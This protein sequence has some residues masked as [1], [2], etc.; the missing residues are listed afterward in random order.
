MDA[1]FINHCN[2]SLFC[3]TNSAMAKKYYLLT[4]GCQMNKNDSQRIAGILDSL[5][6][7]ATQY[8]QEADLILLNTCSVRQ[9]AEDRVFGFVLNWQ[10][11]RVARPDLV[12]G[13]T[14]CMAGRDHDGKLRAKFTGVDLWFGIGN[15][16]MLPVWLRERGLLGESRGEIDKNYLTIAP[17]RDENFRAFIT[18]QTGCDNFCTYCVVPHARGREK[19]RPVAEILTEARAAIDSGAKEIILLGQVVNHYI[20]PDKENFNKGNPFHAVILSEAKD[21]DSFPP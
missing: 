3:Y 17:N 21:L 1:F 18:I 16:P 7:A 4:L 2:F 10:T 15:L 12:I 13:V 14:G 9:S 6:L 5:G 11:L 8:P 20:A 19:N